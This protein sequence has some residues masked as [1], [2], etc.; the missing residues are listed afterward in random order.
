METYH[1]RRPERAIEDIDSIREIIRKERYMTIA[2]SKNNMPYLVTLNYAFDSNKFCFYFHCAK[3]G[4]KKEYIDSNPIIYGQILEDNGYLDGECL[5]LF[6]SV[7]FVGRAEYVTDLKLKREGLNLLIEKQESDPE[8]SKLKFIN[9]KNL[10]RTAI[11][12]ITVNSF[13]GKEIKNP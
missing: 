4:K 8:K 6:R 3:T 13:S 7:Q 2:L 12:K 11:V 10:D 5:H 1:T 9:E